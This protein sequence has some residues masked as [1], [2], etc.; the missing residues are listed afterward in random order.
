MDA[1]KAQAPVETASKDDM[2][3]WMSPANAEP[4]SDNRIMPVIIAQS[5]PFAANSH[6]K[7]ELIALCAAADLPRSGNKAELSERLRVAYEEAYGP[8]ANQLQPAKRPKKSKKGKTPPIAH[9]KNT[10]KSDE[11]DW[12]ELTTT[13]P[14]SIYA[15]LRKCAVALSRTS[16]WERAPVRK[17]SLPIPFG[18]EISLQ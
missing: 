11:K 6:K 1:V 2:K 17:F 9:R 18:R 16:A 12:V 4:E 7:E 8:G 13:T 15:F 14:H 5:Y 10:G 3:E